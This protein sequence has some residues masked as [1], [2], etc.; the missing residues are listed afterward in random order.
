MRVAG[1]SSA[2]RSA[3]FSFLTISFGV[4][5]G[6]KIAFQAVTWNSGS[7]PSLVVGT[8]GSAAARS[9]SAIAYALIVPAWICGTRFT[10]WSHM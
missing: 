3:P 2:F 8:S 9:G 1:S 6:A 4:P 5:F 7:P 10:I